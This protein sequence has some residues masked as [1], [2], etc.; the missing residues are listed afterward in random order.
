MLGLESLDVKTS[1][2][3]CFQMS[4]LKWINVLVK[5]LLN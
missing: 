2:Q 3:M 5:T 1:F 4:Y